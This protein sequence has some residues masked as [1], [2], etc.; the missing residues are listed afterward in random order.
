MRN[1]YRGLISIGLLSL[2]VLSLPVIAHGAAKDDANAIVI[3]FKD[4]HQQSISLSDVARIEFKSQ[5]SA[6]AAKTEVE[7]LGR[8]HFVGK[9]SVGDGNGHTIYFTLEES[10]Q[11]TNTVD[12]GGHGTWTYINGEARVS[13]DNGW[14]DAIRKSGMKHQKFAYAPGKSFDD[15]PENVS[16]AQKANAE[17]I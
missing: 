11:A 12:G 6:V 13:W 1:G 15:K 9:W 14:H 8:R 16:E 7:M 5:A 17:P 4:G 2:A 10:G 3:T